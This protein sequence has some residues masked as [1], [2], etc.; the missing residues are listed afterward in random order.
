MVA[1]LL[2]LVA[3]G[4]ALA[5]WG[6]GE[7][8]ATAPTSTA[9]RL[10]TLLGDTALGMAT[11]LALSAVS[12]VLVASLRR[13]P[14]SMGSMSESVWRWLVPT[15]LRAALLGASGAAVVTS[16]A[17]AIDAPA[18][19]TSARLE[20]G[21]PLTSAAAT[22]AAGT[23]SATTASPGASADAPA[24]GHVV[25]AGDSLW[26]IAEQHLGAG[27]TAAQVAAEW[28]RWYASNRDVVGP[29]PGLLRVGAVLT[30][31]R[32]GGVS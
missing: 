1:R 26:A 9:S 13:L 11:L 19:A 30:A 29:D 6:P 16:S 12:D 2:L 8:S 28:P 21:R 25:V 31:P 20:V 18:T 32:A 4:S 15:A 24:Q 3:G 5:W 27:A 23:T 17:A 10:T 14:G 22:T 7:P